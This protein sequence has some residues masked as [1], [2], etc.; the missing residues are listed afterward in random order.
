MEIPFEIMAEGT[1]VRGIIW[2]QVIRDGIPQL[3]NTVPLR[4]GTVV[5]VLFGFLSSRGPFF[6]SCS[7]SMD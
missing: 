6:E 2:L 7:V 3:I 5:H 1:F 4:T